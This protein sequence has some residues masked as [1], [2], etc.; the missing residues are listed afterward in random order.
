M[1]FT[2]FTIEFVSLRRPYTGRVT[3][4]TDDDL[5]NRSY[6]RL[7]WPTFR[8]SVQL[9]GQEYPEVYTY[10]RTKSDEIPLYYFDM[11]NTDMQERNKKIA[12][13]LG[14]IVLGRTVK[15]KKVRK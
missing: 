13:V 7:G 10:Y 3:E 11:P 12:E 9:P 8:V 4:K 2:E 15:P 14:E 6:Q 5:E 1:P